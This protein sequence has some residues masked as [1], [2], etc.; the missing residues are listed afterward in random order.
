MKPAQA[1]VASEIEEMPMSDQER[2]ARLEALWKRRRCPRWSGLA[3]TRERRAALT[4][5]SVRRMNAAELL[6]GDQPV[7]LDTSTW[8]RARRLPAD[9]LRPLQAAMVGR[10]ALITPIV[11]I[12]ILYSARTAADYAQGPTPGCPRCGCC[13]TIAPAADAAMSALRELAG[14]G[15]R[16]PPRVITPML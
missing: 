16:I 7:V 4:A 10:R 12:E 2:T 14:A 3:D 6:S 11:P 15:R 1:T 13:A 9:V 8:W 5:R